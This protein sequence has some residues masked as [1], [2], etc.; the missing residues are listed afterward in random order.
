[1]LD[2]LT[3]DI[4]ATQDAYLRCERDWDPRLERQCK[5]YQ[6]DRPDLVL[7]DVPYMPLL[8]AQNMGIPNVAFCSLNWADILASL[9]ACETEKQQA[10]TRIEQRIRSVYAGA[11]L[12]IC[13]EP[14]MPMAD[15]SKVLNVG[16]IATLGKNRREALRDHFGWS[17][18]T[19]VVLVDLGG[20]SW[21]PP[22]DRWAES[23]GIAWLFSHRPEQSRAD[24]AGYAESGLL[25]PEGVSFAD[26]LHSCDALLTKPG[27][28][29]FTNG[30]LNRVPILY[31]NRE[32]WPEA[33]YLEAWL[34]RHGKAMAIGLEELE[35]EKLLTALRRLW[36]QGSVP[37]R[38]FDLGENAACEAMAGL[39]GV[40][41]V[42][43]EAF[44][45]DSETK[46]FD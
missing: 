42:R 11:D 31:L 8:A 15:L 21:V 46:P 41:S 34:A 44:W 29:A 45:P 9:N 43:N 25:G 13:P 2:A 22:M 1:M 7:A 18:Q 33:P 23:D 30:T 28:G 6:Q 19:K 20:V 14:S 17:E 40:A 37:E 27:Y 32:G 5:L 26:L 36:T 16:V 38:R 10:L 24:V 4:A 3:I 39:L 12:F 35:G